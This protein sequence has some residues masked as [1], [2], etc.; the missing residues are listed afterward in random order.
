MGFAFQLYSSRNVASQTEFLTE[1][2]NMGYTAVEGYGGLEADTNEFAAAMKANNLS[3]PSCHYGLDDLRADLDAAV[4]KADAMGTKHMIVPYLDAE[5]RPTDR[6]GW[7]SL[8]HELEMLSKVLKSKGKSL[9]WHNHEFEFI[10]TDDG[11]LPIEIL[12][13]EAPSINWEG[14]LAWIIV[15]KQDPAAYVE[16]YA[17]RLIAIHVKDIAPEGECTD[18]DG[19]AD[20]GSGVVDWQSLIDLTRKVAPNTAMIAEHDNPSDP[21][22][23][24]CQ[25]ITALKGY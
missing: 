25:S 4:A 7:T 6:A 1:L 2:A 21:A 16:K 5:K 11:V 14:D 18:E 19:W 13:E 8:A 9:A 20:I 17:D 3:M 12:L 23:F 10:A 15:A 24:A 22:R